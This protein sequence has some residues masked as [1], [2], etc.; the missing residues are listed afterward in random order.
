[1][2]QPAEGGRSYHSEN[3][4]NGEDENDCPQHGN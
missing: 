4:Q 2:Q 3:P 1:V